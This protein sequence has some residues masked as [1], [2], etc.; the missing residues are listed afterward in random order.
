MH[1]LLQQLHRQGGELSGTVDIRL[2]SGVAGVLGRRIARR[3]GIPPHAGRCAMRVHI[4]H[5]A[6]ALHW[7]RRFGDGAAWMCSTFSPTG[8]WPDGCWIEQTGP[9]RLALGVQIENGGWRWKLRRAWL[10]GIPLPRWVLPRSR[11]GKCIEDGRY[12]FDVTFAVPII[13][14]VLSYGGLLDA[15]PFPSTGVDRP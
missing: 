2:G 6:G 11:A 5:D 9:V 4:Y 14:D 3:L 1:P 12:R 8:N 7:D 15:A 10:A 13:G